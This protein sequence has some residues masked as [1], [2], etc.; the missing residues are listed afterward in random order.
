MCA[1]ETMELE[2]LNYLVFQF[3]MAILSFILYCKIY[4]EEK[5]HMNKTIRFV[6]LT[7]AFINDLGMA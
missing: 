6:R 3:D 4:N 2:L 7:K 5:F 1:Y